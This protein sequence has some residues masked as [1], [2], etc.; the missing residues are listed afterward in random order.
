MNKKNVVTKEKIN[1][2][3][4]FLKDSVDW[5]KKEDQGC[6]HFN[7][8]E[9]LAIYIGWSDGWNMADEDII[10]SNTGRRQSGDWVCG[11]A[12]D[13]AVKI[14]ND[15]DCADFEYLDFPWYKD[16]ECYNSSISLKP[17]MGK[18]E[19]NRYAKWLLESFVNITN[20]H[21]KGRVVYNTR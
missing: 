19:Y 5:L 14:R 21:Q 10:K 16:G 15:C 18:R 2:V 7:L 8:S 17:N 11:W 9:D 13:T 6:C 12:I 4:D 3:A 20:E 1:K